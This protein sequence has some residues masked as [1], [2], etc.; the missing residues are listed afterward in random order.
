MNM[1]SDADLMA[2]L[3]YYCNGERFA[4]LKGPKVDCVKVAS[5]GDFQHDALT[6]QVVSVPRTHPI[7]VGKA[8]SSPISEV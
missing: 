8:V 2:Y 4:S 6:Y 1:R 7:F 3:T 5:V